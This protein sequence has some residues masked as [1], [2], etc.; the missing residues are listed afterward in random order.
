[1]SPLVIEKARMCWDVNTTLSCPCLEYHW[2]MAMRGYPGNTAG[3]LGLGLAEGRTGSRNPLGSSLATLGFILFSLGHILS[4]LEASEHMQLPAS[5]CSAGLSVSYSCCF[6]W[7]TWRM[8]CKWPRQTV[9][10]RGL[11]TVWGPW[12]SSA[13][14]LGFPFENSCGHLTLYILI[15]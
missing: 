11:G 2:L 7:S 9:H 4:S 10:R 3:V 13:V 12:A 5:C 1:M 15:L 14:E 8:V 6:L